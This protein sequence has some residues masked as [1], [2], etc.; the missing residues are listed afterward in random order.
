MG[1][2]FCLLHTVSRLVPMA[3]YRC[4]I[5]LTMKSKYFELI[6]VHTLVVFSL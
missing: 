3:L 6:L 5:V 4:V 1:I 2:E